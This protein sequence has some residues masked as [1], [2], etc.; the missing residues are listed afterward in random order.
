MAGVVLVAGLVTACGGSSNSASTTTRTTA[1][2]QVAL[3]T[4]IR[5]FPS[6]VEFEFRSAPSLV[7]AATAMKSRLQEF[8]SGNRVLLSGASAI[9]VRFSPASGSEHSNGRLQLVYKGQRRLLPGTQGIVR[10][11]VRT[12]DSTSTLIW[13]IGID[14]TRR[15]HVSRSG[16]NVTIS[17]S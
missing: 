17:F 11:V 13:A 2:S 12:R 1:Q 5:L 4:N 10:E 7:K 3:L 9:T 14:H 8:P 6:R 15:F 16:A